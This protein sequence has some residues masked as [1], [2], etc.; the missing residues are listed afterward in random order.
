MIEHVTDMSVVSGPGD[1]HLVLFIR[2]EGYLIPRLSS[3]SVIADSLKVKSTKS[4][5]HFSRT[6]SGPELLRQP[7]PK[8]DC[9][10]ILRNES[11]VFMVSFGGWLFIY[12]PLVL[13]MES[14]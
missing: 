1:Y 6:L 14:H 8:R 5:C 10:V 11:R 13:E 3:Q 4:E 9:H 7:V 12:A 2:D